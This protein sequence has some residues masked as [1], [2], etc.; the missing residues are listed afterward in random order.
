LNLSLVT[1]LAGDPRDRSSRRT[2]RR[3]ERRV[4]KRLSAETIERLVAEYRTGSTAAD[5][6]RRYGLAKT[7]V[8]Q[9]IRQAAEPVRHRRFNAAETARLVEL[10][11]AGLSQKDIAERLGRSPSAVWHCLRR[12]D[13]VG[14][15]RTIQ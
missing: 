8:L 4:N 11:E 2:N 12:R 6:G 5:L 15:R 7:T 10:Y 9:L 14:R 1:Y 13:L 3:Q